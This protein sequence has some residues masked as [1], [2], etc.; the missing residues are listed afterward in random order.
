MSPGAA[1]VWRDVTVAGTGPLG[2]CVV[3]IEEETKHTSTK[4]GEW[5]SRDVS[6]FVDVHGVLMITCMLWWWWSDT[7][8]RGSVPDHAHE[9]EPLDHH[10]A[11]ILSRNELKSQTLIR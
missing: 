1:W 9:P 4:K 10:L 6:H 3:F 5:L 7:A 11:S 2:R 8:G